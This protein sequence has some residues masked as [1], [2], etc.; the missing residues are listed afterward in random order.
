MGP[1]QICWC[2]FREPRVFTIAH[3][4][5]YNYMFLYTLHSIHAI[6]L[7]RSCVCIHDV[8]MWSMYVY[9]YVLSVC[10]CESV[11]LCFQT[12]QHMPWEKCPTPNAGMVGLVL[13]GPRARPCSCQSSLA[14]PV[15]NKVYGRRKLRGCSLCWWV[16]AIPSG[17]F[18]YTWKIVFFL[19]KSSSRQ[20]SIAFHI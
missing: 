18:T 6:K 7:P 19:R 9:L 8:Y 4:F 1:S 2:P 16:K 15:G 14:R 11:C 12:W 13:G 5:I 3:I 17:N 10:V 20:C